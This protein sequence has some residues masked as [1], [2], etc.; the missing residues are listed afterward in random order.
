[1]Q[2]LPVTELDQRMQMHLQT[3]LKNHKWPAPNGKALSP[4]GGY[5]MFLG[6][7]KEFKP[8]L[9]V[10]EEM[11]PAVFEGHVRHFPLFLPL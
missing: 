8:D 3:V 1:M 4:A 6:I 7:L 9:V 2:D 10:T 5:N 11:P